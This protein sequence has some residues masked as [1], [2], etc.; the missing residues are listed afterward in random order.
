MVLRHPICPNAEHAEK[1]L[2]C[3]LSELGV[4]P[5]SRSRSPRREATGTRH[6]NELRQAPRFRF[7][8]RRTQRRDAV[9]PPPLVVF[10]RSWPFARF[11]EQSLLEHALNRSIERAGAEL[12]LA[13][14]PYL[15]ILDDG[16]PVPVFFS[17][18]Q[19]DVEGRGLKRQQFVDFVLVD[20]AVQCSSL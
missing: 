13:F 7:R 14:S 8:D 10:F 6:P 19:Q 15:Y 9:I 20:H 16:V 4:Q 11:E 5:L 3:E 1:I 2:L 12:Q 17:H 18:R